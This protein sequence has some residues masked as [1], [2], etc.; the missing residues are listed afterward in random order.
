MASAKAIRTMVSPTRTGL[1]LYGSPSH[2]TLLHELLLLLL[3]LG[4]LL[5]RHL[6]HALLHVGQ[7][8]TC[9]WIVCFAVCCRRLTARQSIR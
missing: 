5:R 4:S 6:L 7:Y 2:V 8:V 1:H 3:V 9:C